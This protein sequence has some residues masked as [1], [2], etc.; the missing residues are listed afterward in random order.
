MKI[1]RFAMVLL[2]ATGLLALGACDGDSDGDDDDDDDVAATSFAAIAARDAFA[3]PV[4]IEN[5]DA[6]AADIEAAF[7]GP[8]DEPVEI[9]EED[10]EIGDL[11]N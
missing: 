5:P 11:L 8:F 10:D 6:L 4:E 2:L 1:R 7:G 3:D 9:T